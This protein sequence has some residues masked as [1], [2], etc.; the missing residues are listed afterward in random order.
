[1]LNSQQFETLLHH[2]QYGDYVNHCCLQLPS[3]IKQN[4]ARNQGTQRQKHLQQQQV[5]FDEIV[6]RRNS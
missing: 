2:G 3:R 1:M 4:V 5:A 6:N